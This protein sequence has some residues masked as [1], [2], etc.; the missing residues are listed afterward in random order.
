ML[1]L[2]SN[3]DNISEYFSLPISYNKSSQKLETHITKDL[4]LSAC[5]DP[6]ATSIYAHMFKPSTC[7]G[8]KLLEIMPNQ[9]TTDETFLKDTQQLLKTYDSKE[10]LS[11][12]DNKGN[13]SAEDFKKVL[14]IYDEIKNDREFREKYCYLDWEQIAFL[15]KNSVFMQ[16]MSVYNLSS[17][18]MSLF[19]PIVML[20]IPFIVIKFK[21]IELNVEEYI[22]I[23][24]QIISSHAIGKVF[25]QFNSVDLQQKIYLLISAAFYL[26]SIYQN[27]LTCRRFYKNM[28]IIYN[29]LRP[30]LKYLNYSA[31]QMRDFIS[32]YSHLT[33]YAAFLQNMQT[34]LTQIEYMQTTFGRIQRL[35]EPFCVSLSTA[36]QIGEVM[37]TFYDVHDNRLNHNAFMYSFGF[38][39]YIDNI[40]GLQSNILS[41]NINYCEFSVK[42]KDK[43]EKSQDKNKKDKD[44]NANNEDKKEEKEKQAT[45]FKGAFYP[46]LIGS[47]PI[48]NSYDL[49]K[50]LI[51][52]G[53][54]AS[55]KTTILKTTLINLIMSQQFGCGCYDS[56]IVNPYTHMHCYLN[57]PDT[58]GRDSLLQAEARRCKE[59][60]DSIDYHDKHDRH[61]CVFDE[62][63]SGTNPEEAIISAHVVMDYLAK[64]KNVSTILTTHYIKLCKQ[65]NTNRNIRNCHMKVKK[66][67]DNFEYSYLL[68]KGI[69]TVKGGVKVLIDMDYPIEILNNAKLLQK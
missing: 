21:G 7:F 13:Y 17:P 52:T 58:M 8:E 66:T 61:F 64:R 60:I 26:F 54:N 57:V 19:L 22:N 24:K 68:E 43:K 36:K 62:L 23:L 59:I 50:H 56:A 2:P 28:E 11:V 38:H 9:Y 18:V 49:Q 53:P 42:R 10:D 39:G 5:L 37:T 51:I 6:T 35:D 15:N 46:A 47:D 20:I 45:R 34:H 67:E 25:T 48:K 29:Y 1:T 12:N 65:L 33:S 55:G 69:S 27:I 4:E 30:L 44:K 63:Y 3:I 41:K 16:L 14:T 31:Q 32:K 40:R